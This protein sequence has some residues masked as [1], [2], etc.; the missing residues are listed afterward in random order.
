MMVINVFTK[1]ATT[2]DEVSRLHLNSITSI[3]EGSFENFQEVV[4]SDCCKCQHPIHRGPSSSGHVGR[5]LMPNTPK[6]IAIHA[7]LSSTLS[8]LTNPA[9]SVIDLVALSSIFVISTSADS[10]GRPSPLGRRRAALLCRV[11]QQ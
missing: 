6:E 8:H 2:Q 11:Q 9:L 3:E 1:P 4:A 10:P 7:L 5:S